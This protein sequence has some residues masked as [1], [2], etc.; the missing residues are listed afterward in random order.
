[1][2]G[3][4]FLGLSFTAGEDLEEACVRPEEGLRDSP[5][6]ITRR[7]PKVGQHDDHVPGSQTPSPETTP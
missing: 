2:N 7:R 6:S 5:V 3:Q 1:M 4:E